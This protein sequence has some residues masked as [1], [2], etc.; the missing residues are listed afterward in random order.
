MRLEALELYWIRMP[1]VGVFVTSFGATLKRDI[2]LVR[3]C[4]DGLAGWGEAGADGAPQ[5]S[6]ET[7]QTCWHIIEDFVAPVVLDRD[8]P[9]EGIGTA[10]ASEFAGW[11]WHPMA[12]A[13]VEEAL[14]DLEA[15]RRGLSLRRLY[16]G[17]RD[18]RERI[19]V[20]I[21]LGIQDDF[22]RLAEQI[23]DGL[24]Q[25]YRRI[26]LKIE[27]GKDVSV[28]EPVRA[29]FGDIPLMVDGNC[30]YSREQGEQLLALDALG[31]VMIEQPL[32]HDDMPGHA[33]LQARL[34][35]PICLDECIHTPRHAEW[36]LDSGACRL[37]NVKA[38]RLGGR[39]AALAVHDLC[40]QRGV[41]VWCGGMLESGVGRLHNIAL[42]SLPNFT[43]P[44]DLSASRRYW[45]KDIIEPEVWVGPDGTVEVPDTPGVAERLREKRVQRH[46]VRQ[47][48]L[49][50]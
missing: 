5:Y 18:S 22:E 20:G 21:S 4:A 29:R 48:T 16:A 7:V 6:Y 24:E 47:A 33:A 11:R 43:L 34:Q 9:E 25:G 37:I 10:M 1:M 28:V 32:A 26:K 35:T 23:A 49:K 14:W 12:R 31:L 50:L 42:A 38:S 15:S 45:A 46:L 44:G 27:P 36:A 17:S 13:A 41:P 3:A 30:G 2:L 19:P 39:S 8:W 40:A